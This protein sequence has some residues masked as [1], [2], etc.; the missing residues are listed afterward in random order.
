MASDL[1]S[2]MMI[3]A[4]GMRT[5]GQRVKVIAE[6]IANANSTADTPGGDPYRRKVVTFKSVFDREMKADLVRID[7]VTTDRSEFSTVYDPVHPASGPNGYYKK[8]N[9]QSL[10]E[11]VDM[12]EAQRSYEA[13]VNMV[14]TARKMLQSTIGLLR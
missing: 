1:Q 11:M 4:S 14:D 6:N 5:Q 2:S 3:S 8:P 13:N 12:R 10:V 7:K 9:V